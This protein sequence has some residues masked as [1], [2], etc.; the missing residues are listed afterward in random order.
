MAFPVD[1]LDNYNHDELEN[2]SEDYLSY[3][4]CADPDI[5]EY[6]SLRDGREVKFLWIAHFIVLN[7]LFT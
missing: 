2:L 6:F 7:A 1:I 4:R 3:L 5:P